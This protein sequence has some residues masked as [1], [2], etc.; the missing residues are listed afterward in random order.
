MTFIFAFVILLGV[1]VNMKK[2]FLLFIFIFLAFILVNNYYSAN[3]SIVLV[4]VN[5]KEKLTE[6]Y[7]IHATIATEQKVSFHLSPKEK[8]IVK[9]NF[10]SSKETIEEIWEEIEPGNEYRILFKDL[11]FPYYLFKH[12]QQLLEIYL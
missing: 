6:K 1:L 8:I 12:N 4:E 5:E 9:K 7:I 11:R 3:L 2:Y 10:S